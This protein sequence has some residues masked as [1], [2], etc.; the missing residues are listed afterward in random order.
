MAGLRVALLGCGAIG[1]FLAQ[2]I[3]D[4]KAGPEVRLVAIVDLPHRAQPLQELARRY[5]CA[6][7]SSTEGASVWPRLRPDVVVEAASADAVREHA[8][9]VVQAGCDLVVLSSG[10]LLDQRL[11]E[12][13]WRTAR[14][15]GRTVWVPSGAI[16]LLDVLNALRA[17]EL[18]EVRLTTRKPP[19]ALAGAPGVQERGLDL[20]GLTAPITVFEGNALEAVRAFPTNVNVAASVS[21]AGLGPAQARVRVVADP[22]LSENVHELYVR[23]PFGEFQACVR[24]RPLPSNPRTSTLAAYSALAVL[25]RYG[26]PV[27]IGT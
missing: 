16:G 13:L 2:A 27:R 6:W 3:A 7:V 24:S 10:A 18:Q 15:S 1:S 20:E 21:L 4:G 14:C 22:S 8:L 25:R 12:E 19:Q 26:E 11:F 23:T 5:G 9:A 17:A